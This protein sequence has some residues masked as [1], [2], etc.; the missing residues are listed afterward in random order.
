MTV[1]DCQNTYSFKPD[2][3]IGNGEVHSSTLCGST[4]LSNQIKSL[5]QIAGSGIPDFLPYYSHITGI[6]FYPQGLS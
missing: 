1:S 3:S 2:H 4:I 6:E 5:P